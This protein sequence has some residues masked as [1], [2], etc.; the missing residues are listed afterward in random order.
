[1]EWRNSSETT[2][3]KTNWVCTVSNLV[4]QHSLAGTGIRYYY[5]GFYLIIEQTNETFKHI[6]CY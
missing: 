4:I 1:M 6:Y 3:L 5:T 2:N